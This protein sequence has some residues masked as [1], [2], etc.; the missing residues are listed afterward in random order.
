MGAKF[1][2]SLCNIYMSIWEE[3]CLFSCDNPFAPHIRWCGRYI[4]DLLL[5]WGGSREEATHMASYMNQNSMNLRFTHHYESKSIDFLDVTLVGSGKVLVYPFRKATACNSILSAKS[6]HPSHVIKNLP[7]GEL[8]RS[9][10]NCSDMDHFGQVEQEVCSRLAAR[11]YPKWSLNRAKNIV[12]HKNRLDLLK[13]AP[14]ARQTK[15][16]PLTFIT[17]YSPQFNA[18]KGIINKY[19][20]MLRN[21]I[22]LGKILKGT[23][24]FCHQKSTYD[25]GQGV[26]KPFSKAQ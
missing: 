10:R 26:T 18:I 13:Q 23:H 15:P 2:P 22:C 11:N 6:C 3:T 17:A 5:M 8:I 7:V 12:A 21:D 24:L 16:P 4:D 1:S 19:L 14:G 9:K 25:R 20:P